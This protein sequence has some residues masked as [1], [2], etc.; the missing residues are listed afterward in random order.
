[1]LKIQYSS[2]LA[3][4]DRTSDLHHELHVCWLSDEPYDQPTIAKDAGSS[5]HLIP[6]PTCHLRSTTSVA[7]GAPRFGWALPCSFAW[8]GSYSRHVNDALS[9]HLPDRRSR[10]HGRVCVSGKAGPQLSIA[11]TLLAERL[12]VQDLPRCDTHCFCSIDLG[13]CQPNALLEGLRLNP[14]SRLVC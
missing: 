5:S 3:R 2:S 13:P 14:L 11:H 7:L 4:P 9:Y 8:G 12:V 1:M 6:L 10:R